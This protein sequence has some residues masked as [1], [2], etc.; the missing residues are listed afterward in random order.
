MWNLVSKRY[1]YF[2]LS[3]LIIVP[4]MLALII[5]GLPL[6]IDFTGGS[7]LKV[8]F[9]TVPQPADAKAVFTDAGFPDSQVQTLGVNSLQ[10]KSKAMEDAT[11]NEVLASLRER[12]GDVTELEFSSV[13]ATI[14]SEVVRS[15]IQ[16]IGIATLGIL[17]YLWLIAFR[18]VPHAF[19]YGL[20]AILGLLHDVL[21]LVSVAA[22]FG[23]L[24]GWQIDSLFLTA[25]LTMLGFSVQDKIV[26]FDRIRENL[27]RR[28]GERFD[29]IVNVSIVQTLARSLVTQLTMFFTMLAL[30]LFGGVTI[31]NF[32]VI[33][34]VALLSGTYSSLFISPQI[35]VMWENREWHR[36]FRR[37]PKASQATAQ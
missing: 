25:V 18:N 36:W 32:A 7:L 15:A 9:A 10:I 16:V 19:R 6:A 11:K 28:R 12:F 3:L 22:L 24:L 20:A 5:N 31:H 21:I 8:Q 34:L 37:K 23:T 30:A 17:L 33:L 14:G 27:V 1:W 4:G 2:A 13:S 29:S 26:V 35:L